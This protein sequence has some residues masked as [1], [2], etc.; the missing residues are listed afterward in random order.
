MTRPSTTEATKT[1]AKASKGSSGRYKLPLPQRGQ[2]QP[3]VY[4]EPRDDPGPSK[5]T[6][7]SPSSDDD[8]RSSA[9]SLAQLC[10]SSFQEICQEMKSLTKSSGDVKLETAISMSVA[11]E[12][13]DEWHRVFRDGGIINTPMSRSSDRR[14]PFVTSVVMGLVEECAHLEEI[15]LS[16]STGEK[17]EIQSWYMLIQEP[18]RASRKW[19]AVHQAINQY[20]KYDERDEIIYYSD[21]EDPGKQREI[22]NP[23]VEAV[24]RPNSLAKALGTHGLPIVSWETPLETKVANLIRNQSSLDVFVPGLR[25]GLYMS[26][27]KP[28][29]QPEIPS[30]SKRDG[31]EK[32]SQEEFIRRLNEFDLDDVEYFTD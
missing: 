2:T 28:D 5:N 20:Y 10:S 16:L 27:H 21:D 4:H 7:E 8:L 14:D 18:D 17:D 23:E 11:K 24:S 19:Q 12:E 9:E 13:F 29:L 3:W 15:D 32:I 22:P 30:I 31:K 25:L 6:Y 26:S 1:D